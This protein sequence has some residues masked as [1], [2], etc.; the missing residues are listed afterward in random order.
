MKAIK[1]D[2]NSVQLGDKENKY[3]SPQLQTLSNAH[4]ITPVREVTE[5][6]GQPEMGVFMLDDDQK[7]MIELLNKEIAHLEGLRE[8]VKRGKRGGSNGET[9][10]RKR[11][12]RLGAMAQKM[13]GVMNNDSKPPFSPTDIHKMLTAAGVKCS[14]AQIRYTLKQHKDKY[15][16]NPDYGLWQTMDQTK[17]RAESQQ[18]EDDGIVDR[19]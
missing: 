7:K 14:K 1:R 12:R 8:R 6:N 13:I 2:R 4:P 10:V 11:H 3:L 16:D 19:I 17:K 15:F 5:I 9:P 18:L